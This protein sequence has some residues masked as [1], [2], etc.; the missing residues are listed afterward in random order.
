MNH[1]SHCGSCLAILLV[2]FF[3]VAAFPTA[4][5][6][7]PDEDAPQGIFDT[8]DP[9]ELTLTGELKPILKDRS[10]DRP[11]RPARLW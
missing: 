11:Y 7:T 2:V 5:A 10:D 3:C 4:T 9:L 6:A 8:E 1:A